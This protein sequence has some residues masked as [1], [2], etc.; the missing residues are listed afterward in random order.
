M[1]NSVSKTFIPRHT[2]IHLLPLGTTVAE[3]PETVT[4]ALPAGSV[5]IGY[6]SSSGE[7]LGRTVDT[8]PLDSNQSP[9]IRL[10]ATGGAMTFE[11]SALED[12]DVVRNLATGV[13]PTPGQEYVDITDFSTIIHRVISYLV[14]DAAEGFQKAKRVTG[15]A[16]I[17][18]NGATSYV[19]G[20]GVEVSFTATFIGTVREASG[21]TTPAGS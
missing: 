13:A 2:A 14:V 1:T 21:S 17:V 10:A 15:L 6:T 8:T 19:R 5:A 4:E 12:S 11:F 16:A 7:T 18:P 9:S 20:Q 3:Y